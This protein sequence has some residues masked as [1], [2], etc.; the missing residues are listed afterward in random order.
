MAQYSLGVQHEI[1]PSLILIT[2]YVGN[3]AWHQNDWLPIN[4]FP[5]CTSNLTRADYAGDTTFPG[6]SALSSVQKLNAAAYPGFGNIR[7]QENPLTGSY[8]SFQVG[9]RQQN[10]HGLSY[11]ADY[12][13][14]H[15]IDDTQSSVDV[16]NNNPS[17]N[18]WNL[19]Y[20]KGSGALDRRQVFSGNY[21]YKM[22]FFN[23]ANGLEK[24][25][26]GG[27]E[28]SGTVI[29]ETGLPWLGQDAP[30]AGGPDTVGLGGDY[31]VR[32]NLTG[33]PVYTKG[34]VAGGYQWV[35]STNFSQPTPSWWGGPNL[36]FGNA[37]K[38][39]VVGPG[40]T[41]FTTALDKSFAIG[42]RAHFDF[43]AE[44]F[45]TF[46]HT[47]FNSIN[48]SF[49]FTNG[50]PAANFG[51]TNGTQDPREFEFGLKLVY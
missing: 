29:S 6:Y 37:G 4:N 42:E 7:L 43:R 1:A 10:K 18:P 25:A 21:E 19:K 46:N 48:N 23:H 47:Q 32:P 39:A 34:K 26:L 12:T 13:Y 50:V 9:L 24:T 11:E 49:N 30:S 38:D 3:L 33:K 27:W 35:S 5:L 40:R 45:N 15:Q 28:V 8:N 31:R 22:P 20:D 41:N 51:L 2:Q 17:Y 44:A 16:D 14:A 36:G